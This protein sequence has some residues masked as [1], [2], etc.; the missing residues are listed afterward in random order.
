MSLVCSLYVLKA[1]LGY[2]VVA[3]FIVQSETAENIQEL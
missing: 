1:M 2:S 3:E